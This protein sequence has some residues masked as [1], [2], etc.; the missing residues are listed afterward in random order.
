MV[1]SPSKPNISFLILKL[2]FIWGF[3]FVG[4]PK[5]IYAQESEIKNAINQ[6]LS[7]LKTTSNDSERI[8]LLSDL[9]YAYADIN[10]TVGLTYGY[11]AEELAK[12]LHWPRGKGYVYNNLGNVYA[13]LSDYPKALENY[14]K[15]LKNNELAQHEKAIA[16][17][18]GNI[19]V[20]Y[21]RQ[22][23]YDKSLIYYQKSLAIERKLNNPIGVASDLTNIGVTY[24]SL[25]DFKK[26]LANFTEALKISNQINDKEGVANNTVNI[27]S[28]YEDQLRYKKAIEYYTSSMVI[29]NERGN[30]AGIASTLGSLGSVYLKLLLDTTKNATIDSLPTDKKQIRNLAYNYLKKSETQLTELGARYEMYTVY[31]NL[32]EL[33]VYDKDYKSAM[34]HFERYHTLKD[35]VF[36]QENEARL[37]GLEIRREVDIKEKEIEINKLQLSKVKNQRIGLLIGMLLL[38]IL[39]FMVIKQRAQSEKLLLNILPK[40]IA[41]RLKKKEFPIAD[42]F[43]SASIVF[44]DIVGF[45]NISEKNSPA[46]MVTLLNGVFVQLDELVER[47]G[48]EKIK[49]IGD[50]YMAVGNLPENL[51]NHQDAMAR[52]CLE[53]SNS[54]NAFKTPEGET[55]SFRTGIDCGPVVAGV[56]GEKK[57]IY[58]LWG[59][60]VNTASRMESTGIEGKIQI[61]ERFKFSLSSSF[62]CSLRGPID[63]KGKGKMTTYFLEGESE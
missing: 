53:A 48:L 60:A 2:I 6:L 31:F 47:H 44:I 7:E 5:T 54:L 23:L 1:F 46:N 3:V 27:G 37:A 55:L 56:I 22:K 40:K 14:F 58:D 15:A 10:P 30:K 17:N 36:S 51:A 63:I 45:T 18:L 26:A 50:C 49:T 32:Y 9:S 43:E 12:T 25:G 20:I 29:D 11:K 8:Y 41:E 19:G 42:Q 34:L 52:F 13:M 24:R 57:F 39:A 21:F 4:A 59:D 35:S 61:T 62:K 16:S 33:A 38:G 28:I